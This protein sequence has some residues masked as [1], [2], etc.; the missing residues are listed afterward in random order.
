MK[1]LILLLIVGGLVILTVQNLEPVT[2][3]FFGSITM[4]LPI[5]G[6]VLLFG[7]GGILTSLL[8]QFLNYLQR[9]RS[10]PR[11]SA[12]RSFVPEPEPSPREYRPPEKEPPATTSTGA[13]L[14]DWENQP[15][16]WE[17]KTKD[18]EEW[19]IEEPPPRSAVLR[20]FERRLRQ[21]KPEFEESQSPAQSPTRED[22]DGTPTQTQSGVYSYGYLGAEDTGM[23]QSKT[24][25]QDF[26]E[27][28][29]DQSKSVYDANYRIIT[30]P[31]RKDKDR[32]LEPEA[33][34]EDWV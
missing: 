15:T 14:S 6:W 17:G 16:D 18:K 9:G 25:E 29:E 8:I 32:P 31:Y 19:N 4:S 24:D 12:Y 26:D 20:D 7:A 11:A 28:D 13:T 34:D 23:R 21:D 3:V 1:L 2:L 5:A 33:E 30:P 10:T 22:S 27:S